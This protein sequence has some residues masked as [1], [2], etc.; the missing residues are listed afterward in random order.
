[1]SRSK[2]GSVSKSAFSSSSAG[3]SDPSSPPLSPPPSFALDFIPGRFAVVVYDGPLLVEVDSEFLLWQ[4]A[5][6]RARRLSTLH[7]GSDRWA[8]AVPQPV[9]RATFTASSESRSA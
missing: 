4:D 9:S 6:G 2:L 5:R 7:T 3:F 8:A 1:M